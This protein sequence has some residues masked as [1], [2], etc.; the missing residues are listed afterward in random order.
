[1]CT[2]QWIV[3]EYG[4]WVDLVQI[5]LVVRWSLGRLHR[6]TAPAKS[7]VYLPINV[8]KIRQISIKHSSDTIVAFEF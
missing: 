8:S 7:P 3:N 4:D 6:R 5:D 1:M 2:L